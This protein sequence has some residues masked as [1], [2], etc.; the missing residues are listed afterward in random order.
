MLA[1][2]A[3]KISTGLSATMNPSARRETFLVFGAPRDGAL[4]EGCAIFDKSQRPYRP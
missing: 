2:Q 1:G 4:D 3:G